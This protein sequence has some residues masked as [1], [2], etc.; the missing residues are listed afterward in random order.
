MINKIKSVFQDV[1]LKEILSKG[2]S[3]LLL[4]LGG[5]II[6]YLFTL[7]ITVK[8][9]ANTYGLIALCFSIFLI[10]SVVGKLGLDTNVL[11]FFSDDSNDK[12]TGLFF[13]SILK[14]LL[15]SSIIAILLYLFRYEF[16]YYIFKEP[17]PQLLPYLPWILAAIPFWSANHVCSGYLRA[18][19]QTNA[20]AFFYNPSRF[21]FSLL[22]LLALYTVINNPIIVIQA[23]FFGVLIS[24][25]LSFTWVVFKMKKIHFKN[26]TSSWVF[27]KN[28]LP[29]MFSSSILILLG[30]MDTFVMGI[31]E[32]DTEIGIY[33]VSLKVATLAS[34]SLEAINSILAPKIAKSY[35][36]KE[37]D[38]FK[39]L[40][41][42]S[43][44][45]NFTICCIVIIFIILFNDF[46]LAL[47]GEEFLAGSTILFIFCFGQ[48]VNSFS[49]S[50]G[51]ILQ[52]MGKQK[53]YQNIVLIALAL[54]LIATFILT[55]IYGGIGAATA[56][57]LSMMF[58]N[59][60]GAMYLKIKLNITSYFN[61]FQKIIIKS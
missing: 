48:F 21:L 50:V 30:W 17:K 43:T 26:V 49:G 60:A 56:T 16:V 18:K 13:K 19:K 11:K 37:I 46:L 25:F 12:E 42:F 10:L 6:G 53:V 44:K 7:F 24:F 38:N 22:I 1:D 27:T 28:A 61:P 23:H 15:F 40:I 31:Y 55:P 34:F 29:M 59:L 9:G 51:V 41:L 35:W 58:W 57:V 47:F 5:T 14:S 3:F 52:M 54:N 39:K 33:N 32:T 36:K 20:F 45:L 8:F 4:K 2:F